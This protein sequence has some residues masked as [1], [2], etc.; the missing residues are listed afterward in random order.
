[1]N[2][3][4]QR[5]CGQPERQE[6]PRTKLGKGT[7]IGVQNIEAILFDMPAYSTIGDQIEAIGNGIQ[8]GMITAN[9]PFVSESKK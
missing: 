9:V 7:E 8:Q 2:T 5:A 3:D 6:N 4:Y 1:M